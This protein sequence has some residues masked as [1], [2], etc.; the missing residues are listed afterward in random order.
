M[1]TGGKLYVC[2]PCLQER[3]IGEEELIDEAEISGA[4]DFLNRASDS[5]VVLVY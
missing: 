3:G 5:D 2:S 4:V 1:E